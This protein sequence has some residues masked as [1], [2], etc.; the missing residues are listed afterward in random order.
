MRILNTFLSELTTQSNTAFNF[1]TLLMVFK[2]RRTRRTRRDLIVLRF[3]PVELP[4]KNWI[5]N[6]HSSSQKAQL[7]HLVSSL[8]CVLKELI[9]VHR[10]KYFQNELRKGNWVFVLEWQN[11]V[12]QRNLHQQIKL[13]SGSPC[14][15]GKYISPFWTLDTKIA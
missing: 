1:G 3:W 7:P 9:L 2:G 5:Q 12:W 11:S 10:C 8:Q 14:F 15:L 6:E 4:L 13:Y